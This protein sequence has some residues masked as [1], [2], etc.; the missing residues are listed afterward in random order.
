MVPEIELDTPDGRGILGHDNAPMLYVTNLGI[1]ML[2]VWITE[3]ERWI[4]YRLSD[5]NDI[6]PSDFT[7]INNTEHELQ[8]ES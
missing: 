1:V 7:I 8:T 5:I 4:N 6:L 2:K 3:K